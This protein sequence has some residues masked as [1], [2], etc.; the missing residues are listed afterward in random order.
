MGDQE[1]LFDTGAV[2]P[3]EDPAAEKAGGVGR[4][5]PATSQAAALANPGKRATLRRLV[6][7]LFKQEG[8]GWTDDELATALA[9]QHP[10]SVG[11]RRQELVE[12]GWLEDSSF[13]RETRRGCD[14]I[15]WVLTPQGRVQE[16]E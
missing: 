6:L 5:S 4:S 1:T 10:G 2:A 15:V 8:R 11:K 12:M 13:R 7:L 9:G 3:L 14:A 16:V